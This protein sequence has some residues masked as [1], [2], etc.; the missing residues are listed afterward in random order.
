MQIVEAVLLG[1]PTT[2][3]EENLNWL[4]AFAAPEATMDE[5]VQAIAH[6]LLSRTLFQ[7]NKRQRQPLKFGHR[8]PKGYLQT[9]VMRRVSTKH[10]NVFPLPKH[11]RI[12]RPP[13]TGA[14]TSP[15]YAANIAADAAKQTGSEKLVAAIDLFANPLQPGETWQKR[16][17]KIAKGIADF[18]GGRGAA[19]GNAFDARGNSLYS[20]AVEIING[21]RKRFSKDEQRRAIQG[22]I[23]RMTREIDASGKSTRLIP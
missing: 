15:I 7:G 3:V 13:V 1:S 19:F 18:V 20:A 6:G 16:D 14:A 21:V 22:E 5:R 10:P 23:D 4:L 17:L 12:V 8:T 9:D 11:P 2:A